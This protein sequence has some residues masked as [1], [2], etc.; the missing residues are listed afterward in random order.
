MLEILE[1]RWESRGLGPL[2]QE[3]AE[4]YPKSMLTGKFNGFSELN[5][6]EKSRFGKWL[7]EKR[8]Y[9]FK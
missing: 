3:N 8:W 1:E 4:K 2:T 6:G 9:N 5:T 7:R